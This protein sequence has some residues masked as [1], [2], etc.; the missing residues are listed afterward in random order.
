MGIF[1]VLFSHNT[2][3]VVRGFDKNAYVALELYNVM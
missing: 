1:I 3:P 2:V